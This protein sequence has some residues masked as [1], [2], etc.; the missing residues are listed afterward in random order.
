M[1]KRYAGVS[2]RCSRRI[3]CFEIGA[4]HL[5]V[6]DSVIVETDRGVNMGQVVVPPEQAELPDGI[7]QEGVKKV[8]RKA[9]DDDFSKLK[10]NSEREVEAAQVCREKIKAYGLK[11][12][13]VRAE[14][15]HDGNRIIFYFTAENRVDFRELVKELAH[16]LHVRVEMRQIG[17]RDAA[18]MLGGVGIC[19]RELCCAT[20]LSTFDPVTVK[21][22]KEQN[23][24]LNPMKISGICGRLM[25]CLG[26]EYES[27]RQSEGRRKSRRKSRSGSERESERPN[28]KASENEAAGDDLKTPEKS[29]EKTGDKKRT[30]APSGDSRNKKSS[31]NANSRKGRGSR[32]GKPRDRKRKS[33]EEGTKKEEGI[34]KDGE[35][36]KNEE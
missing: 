23:L 15:M 29:S 28:R 34:K 5:K 8:L 21:M 35:I 9:R 6:N 7:A 31:G 14:L 10:E 16:S 17:I 19:G 25:C 33:N 2:F 4:L 30:E 36:K 32:G 13:L 26:Y 3:Y 18:G 22:A 12:K 27:Y 24:A 11:M 20:F 1:V